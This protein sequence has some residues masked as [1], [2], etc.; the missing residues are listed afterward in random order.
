MKNVLFITLII[1]A[2]LHIFGFIKAFNIIAINTTF[3]PISRKQGILWLVTGLL[4]LVSAE[5]LF[6][7]RE[8]WWLY[9]LVAVVFSQ[10]L[11]VI[12]WEDAKYATLINLLLC[13]VT[14]S[15][16]GA[17][18]F[19]TLYKED[20]AAELSGPMVT[21][22]LLKEEDMAH[23]PALVQKYLRYT[24]SVGKKKVVNFR[25]DMQGELRKK[26]GAWMPFSSEQFNFIK[27]GARYFFMRARMKELPVTGF[28]R[29]KDGKASMDIR[30]F[31]LVKVQYADGVAMD[32]SET[33]TFLNDMCCMAPS[34][35]I[36]RRITWLQ[37]DSQ[38][39]KAT[40]ANRN[41]KVSAYLYFN[42]KGE[43][44]NFTSD[45]RY[46]V[47]DDGKMTRLPWSTPLKD[48][49]DINGYRLA[50]YAE[51]VY[52]YPEGDFCYGRFFIKSIRYNYK[53]PKH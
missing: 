40:F 46:A 22:S 20:V 1:H 18:N 24:G 7:N 44:V 26:E 52:E 36:D 34:T 15:G 30:L 10:S 21:E 25:C 51:T 23:L 12:N 47:D 16:F 2:I 42:A 5:L 32:Q 27:S 29:F 14:L 6:L 38:R 49:R 19:H 31:S 28:H 39:V 33:V 41:I 17:W 3:L 50:T 9:G 11:V 8:Y 43:L 48:Y 53:D 4:L 37:I 45:D 35:L 13:G